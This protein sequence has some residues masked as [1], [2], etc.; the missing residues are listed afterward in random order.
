MSRPKWSPPPVQAH[1]GWEPPTKAPRTGI[2]T[3]VV[4]RAAVNAAGLVYE[5]AELVNRVCTQ[6]GIE[7]GSLAQISLLGK[8]GEVLGR[9]GTPL[10]A[11]DAVLQ[12]VAGWVATDA[13]APA[14]APEPARH[15]PAAPGEAQDTGVAEKPPS[16]GISD[17]SMTVGEAEAEAKRQLA[18]FEAWASA[19]RGAR[20][21][22]LAERSDG[23]L[24]GEAIASPVEPPEQEL[25]PC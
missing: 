23:G 16:T 7:H 21:A 18:E 1:R 20:E 24:P 22:L 14:V 8:A 9:G 6:A 10:E 13:L 15:A 3:A 19:S 17:I 2:P 4:E 12:I 5:T 25:P 11:R